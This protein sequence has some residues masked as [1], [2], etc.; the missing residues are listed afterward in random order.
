[1]IVGMIFLIST[2]EA[3]FSAVCRSR[4]FSIEL[5][6]DPPSVRSDA[7][8]AYPRVLAVRTT[9]RSSGLATG[10][11]PNNA[12]AMDTAEASTLPTLT[13]EPPPLSWREDCHRARLRPGRE[14]MGSSDAYGCRAFSRI[15]SSSSSDMSC[16][17]D[18]RHHAGYHDTYAVPNAAVRFSGWRGGFFGKA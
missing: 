18:R 8:D 3:T 12:R 10:D 9:S 17:S 6:P 15:E 4:L 5:I 2:Q 14:A 16:V 13:R 11:I 7:E 1:M